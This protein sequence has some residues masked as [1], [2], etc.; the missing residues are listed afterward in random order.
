MASLNCSNVSTPYGN[1]FHIDLMTPTSSSLVSTRKSMF[2][3]RPGSMY[4]GVCRVK[5]Q[6]SPMHLP[7]TH[8][9]RNAESFKQVMVSTTTYARLVGHAF[10]SR[11]KH[12]RARASVMS[13]PGGRCALWRRRSL[14]TEVLPDLAGPS[15]SVRAQ[16]GT[17][18]ASNLLSI[19][20][21]RD[22]SRQ[23]RTSR[24]GLRRSPRNEGPFV[25]GANCL[26]SQKHLQGPHHMSPA[27]FGPSKTLYGR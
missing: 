18:P 27:Q 3:R 2:D 13:Q 17:E 19:K 14:H 21:F 4:V 24:R 25:L 22:F 10:C 16:G 5:T 6:N 23:R 20:S 7:L 15:T 26:S 1:I 12:L 11:M 9:S 8:A